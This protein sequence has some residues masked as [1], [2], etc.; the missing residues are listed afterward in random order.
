MKN[1]LSYSIIG[2]AIDR[3]L[4]EIDC[5]NIRDFA[6]NQYGQV[7][8]KFYGGG[9][10][11][12]LMVE[13]VIKTWLSLF[14]A[15]P[16]HY[17]AKHLTYVK[18]PGALRGQWHLAPPTTAKTI[19][20]SPRGRVFNQ[21][22]AKKL[23][24]QE[25]LIFLC[26]HYEGIDQRAIDL[27]QAEEISLG[28]FV[29]TGGETA[30]IPMI[31]AISRLIPGVL[32]NEEAYQRE[33]HSDGFLEEAQYTRPA[34]WH[35]LKV[36]EVLLSGNQAEIDSY[37]LSCRIKETLEKRPDLFSKQKLSEAEFLSFLQSLEIDT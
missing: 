20:L 34:D 15:D 11:M 32:P 5:H 18:T 8:A 25:H 10:G 16:D 30:V 31:D 33:S 17:L 37:R 22:M 35:G 12:L 4:I 24:T 9:T 21:E 7:D 19:F 14:V 13:P 3:G 1:S 29:L 26:G 2:R 27:M 6:I 36:P 23:A 28:D